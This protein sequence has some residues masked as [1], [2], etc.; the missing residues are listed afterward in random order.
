[1][2]EADTI[3]PNG[4]P[5]TINSLAEQFAE[6]GLTAG[7]TVLVHSRMSALGWVSG[8]AVAVIQALLRVLTP[9]GTLM[10]PTFSPETT[11]PATW[12][13]PSM[14]EHW[15]PMIRDHLPAYDARIT[16][17][18]GMGKIAELFRT[19]PGVI[20]GDHPCASFAAIGPNARYL[21]ENHTSLAR[22]LDDDSP[23]GKL[24]ALDGYVFLLGTNHGTN[25]SLHLAEYRTNLPE[26]YITEWVVMMVDG[27]R[28]WVSYEMFNISDADFVELGD[29]YEATY[30]IPRGRVGRA[31][32][33]FMKQKPLVDFAVDWLEKNRRPS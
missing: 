1:M 15:L 13:D 2:P 28:Q 16:P 11:D 31:D 32:V 27:V 18:F 19:Y 21:V 29:A 17:T 12:D 25:T 22:F 33:R 8:G 7:Q 4:L 14:P 10:M 20:R 26:S 9:S 5:L 30:N 24:Y 23:V 6:C 3:D